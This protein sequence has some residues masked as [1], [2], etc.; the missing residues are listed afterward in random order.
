MLAV[1]PN[2]P[3]NREDVLGYY[4]IAAAICAGS[5]ILSHVNDGGFWIVAK[6]FNMTVK[7]TL[8]TW[9]VLETILSL[10]GFGM[11]SLLWVII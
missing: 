3:R 11:A 2:S 9:S 8:L 7:E 4:M 10:V 5:I 6:Y 1:R